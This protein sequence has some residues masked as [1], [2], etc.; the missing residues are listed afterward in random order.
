MREVTELTDSELKS[1]TWHCMKCDKR[2]DQQRGF[3]EHLGEQGCLELESYRKAN[4]YGAHDVFMYSEKYDTW[5][6]MDELLIG[7]T[8]FLH[9]LEFVKRVEHRL[10]TMNTR[11]KKTIPASANRTLL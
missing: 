6:H 8:E 3:A 7:A 1:H 5:V 2:I 4:D 9:S 10:H 11:A